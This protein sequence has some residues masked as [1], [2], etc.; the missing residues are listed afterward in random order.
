LPEIP[1][2]EGKEIGS[3]A[4]SGYQGEE[5]EFARNNKLTTGASMVKGNQE[6]EIQ[7]FEEVLKSE[8]KSG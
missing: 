6:E 5:T 8:P 7:N 1:E 4:K 2:D 3:A